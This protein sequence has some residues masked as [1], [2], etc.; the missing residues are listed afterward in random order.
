VAAVSDE[1]WVTAREDPTMVGMLY[2]ASSREAHLAPCRKAAS[3]QL[4]RIIA[5]GTLAAARINS[6]NEWLRALG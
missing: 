5:F 3:T 1:A 2:V 6:S 4:P